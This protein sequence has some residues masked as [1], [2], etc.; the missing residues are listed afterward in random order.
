MEVLNLNN[1]FFTHVE[2][3][4]LNKLDQLLI[5]VKIDLREAL[6]PPPVCWQLVDENGEAATIGTLGNF[7]LV[8]GKAKSRKSFLMC[9]AVSAAVKNGL[10]LNRFRGTLPSNQNEVLYFDTEQG[11]YHVQK[12]AKRICR[13]IQIEEPTNLTVYGLRRYA[14]D[15]R[16]A[17][18]EHALY[19]NERIGFVVIDGIKDLVKSINDE[20]EATTIASKL[21]KWTEER[22]I[23]IVTVLH[24]NK[25][26]NNA[27]GH[28]GSELT[29]KA[30]TVLSVAKSPENKDISIVEAE[31]CRDKEPEPFAFE[32]DD[33]GL[34]VLSM[35][36][37]MKTIK[38]TS[39]I[40]VDELTTEQLEGL[41]SKSFFKESELSY[42]ELKI[43][44]KLAFKARM[45]RDIGEN[46][47][48]EIITHCRNEGLVIQLSP[49]GKYRR[50]LN[51]E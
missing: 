43:Q 19:S 20:A 9:L 17:L 18:I 40:G 26:D 6:T 35:D 38:K 31:Y 44:I 14:P 48:K 30:E 10:L 46:K 15:V 37:Q 47:T 41:L 22:N 16:L 11:K 5:E 13:L 21:L 45:G 51:D 39:K 2:N 1:E 50:N 36:W 29:N 3:E 7:S 27:R 4:E 25:A 23:H 12:A 49:K 32:I 42:T 8:I 34:P 28:L 24:Q 33:E